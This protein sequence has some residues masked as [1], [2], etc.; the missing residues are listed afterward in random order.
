MTSGISIHHNYKQ[1]TRVGFHAFFG[2]GSRAGN[3]Q[4]GE[5]SIVFS[6]RVELMAV[7]LF[8]SQ[9]SLLG[10]VIR[11]ITGWLASSAWYARVR[12]T[13]FKESKWVAL[14]TVVTVPG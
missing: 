1:F 10:G 9:R 8:Y 4:Q 13:E 7:N 3:A 12:K 2:F 11:C 5:L 6:M 14:V